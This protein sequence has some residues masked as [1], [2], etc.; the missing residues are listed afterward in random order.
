M[1]GSNYREYAGSCRVA[2]ELFE[3][4][5]HGRT[6]WAWV[7]RDCAGNMLAHS[8]NFFPD[9]IAC[10]CDAQGRDPAR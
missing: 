8:E 3:V 4:E 9:Y 5:L 7:K 10:L 6:F 1:L 2:A